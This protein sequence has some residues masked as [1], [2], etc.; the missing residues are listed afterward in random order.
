[1]SHYQSHHHRPH[2]ARPHRTKRRLL[3][4]PIT[5]TLLVLGVAVLLLAA[6]ASIS[7]SPS[8]TDGATV[9]VKVDRSTVTTPVAASLASQAKGLSVIPSLTD[10]QGMLF[11]FEQSALQEFWMKGLTYPIDIIWIDQETVSEV[12]PNVQPAEPNTADESLPRYKP[13]YP[14]N[15][16]LEVPAGWAARHN[17]QPGDP[18]HIS[19]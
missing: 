8:L 7:G 5:I 4:H 12:T 10:E 2:P 19:G 11:V 3:V 17:I 6:L 13:Q 14:V 1:M 18:V 15:R 16:V 9:K